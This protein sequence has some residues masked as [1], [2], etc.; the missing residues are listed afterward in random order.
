MWQWYKEPN[1][2]RLFE[3]LLLIANHTTSQLKGNTIMRGQL[4]TTINDL[5]NDTGLSVRNIRTVLSRLESFGDIDTKSTNKYT[6][7]TICT[8]DEYIDKEGKNDTQPTNDRQTT[9]KRLTNGP[10]QITEIQ[11]SVNANNV[12][13]VNN[14]NKE[15]TN[16]FF[17][18]N[19]SS[20]V[21]SLFDDFIRQEIEV[22]HDFNYSRL[23]K[24][25][26]KLKIIAP[27]ETE[28]IAV[29]KKAIDN[30]SNDFEPLTDEEK[31]EI[32]MKFIPPSIDEVIELF[33]NSGHT[34][35]EA[36]E[37]FKTYDKFKWIGKNGVSRIPDWKNSMKETYQ[38]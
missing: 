28:K 19:F 36:S 20:E 6:F 37:A 25:I 21:N 10:L 4:I 14:V 38:L 1:T 35:K 13:N 33:E 32:D 31:S 3:H 30:V 26:K 9:D 27:S 29:L 11:L 22:K 23:R 12:K 34:A 5:S 18:K 17:N 7:I 24:L 15:E 16:K 2:A 8:Y